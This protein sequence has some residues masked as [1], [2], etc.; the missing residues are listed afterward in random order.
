MDTFDH[1][2]FRQ[3]SFSHD[4]L[5]FSLSYEDSTGLYIGN[6][7][8]FLSIVFAPNKDS[9]ISLEWFE[10]GGGMGG[11]LSTYDQHHIIIS[12]LLFDSISI[13]SSDSGFSLHD[14]SI[15][16]SEQSLDYEYPP[17]NYSQPF[18]TFTYTDF[19]ASSVTLSGIFRPTTFSN[20]PAIVTEAPQPNTLAIYT[21]NGS[22]ACSFDVA[23]HARDLGIFSP[24]GIREAS[25]TIHAGQT[26]ASLPHLPPGFYFVRL[27]GA[28][29]KIY[30]SGY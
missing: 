23:D 11:T 20:P 12:S 5:Q 19:T 3:Y 25:A 28:M 27:D 26:D 1:N 9:I 2:I 17:N 16:D 10:Q 22:I 6:Y 7:S 24:L 14:I 13:F 18:G 30:I 29:S 21:S 15:A 4:V 8:E